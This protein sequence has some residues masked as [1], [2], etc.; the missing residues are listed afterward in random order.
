MI[1]QTRALPAAN[2]NSVA[3]RCGREWEGGVIRHE[4]VSASYPSNPHSR[5]KWVRINTDHPPTVE[6]GRRRW[7]P[8]LNM[9][10]REAGEQP[11]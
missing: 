9:M 10:A 2:L 3:A 11:R 7:L 4:T 6:F 1:A 8:V 5:F